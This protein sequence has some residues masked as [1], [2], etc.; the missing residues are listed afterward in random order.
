[1]ARQFMLMNENGRD[2]RD[3]FLGLGK[4]CKKLGIALWDY[5]GATL[6]VPNA[7]AVPPP[8]RHHRCRG[9]PA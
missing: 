4:T 6:G 7:P 8:C 5:L 3:A 1:L 2:C 9:Q